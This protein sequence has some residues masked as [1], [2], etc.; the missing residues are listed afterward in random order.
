MILL[1]RRKPP[2]DPTPFRG[3]TAPSR[4]RIP[5]SFYLAAR[6]RF[7]LEGRGVGGTKV[8]YTVNRK[9]GDRA[10]PREAVRPTDTGV[11]AL[12]TGRMSDD[13]NSVSGNGWKI[14]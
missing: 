5:P 3:R 6:R 10:I 2:A 4:C 9:T 12:Y 13:G 11:T 7:D 1:T 8:K 14:T